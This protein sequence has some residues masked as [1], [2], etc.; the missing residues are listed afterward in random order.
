VSIVTCSNCDTLVDSDRDGDC[1]EGDVVR[2]KACR[3]S[4]YIGHLCSDCP[5]IGYPTN[6]TRCTGC[7]RR[8]IRLNSPDADATLSLQERAEHS[9]CSADP[10]LVEE[11]ADE[12]ARTNEALAACQAQAA[13]R[14][15]E[16]V[17][18]GYAL[19]GMLEGVTQDDRDRIDVAA[20]ITQS[21]WFRRQEALIE[22][23]LKVLCPDGEPNPHLREPYPPASILTTPAVQS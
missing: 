7:P 18:I 3:E 21:E 1:F 16:L 11:L 20:G 22:R 12:L 6:S 2:C 23:A 17:D 15:R 9:F 14:I 4:P 19:A 13:G 5:P 8:D 10:T